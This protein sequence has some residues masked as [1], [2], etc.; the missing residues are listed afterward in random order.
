MRPTTSASNLFRRALCPGSARMEEGLPDEESPQSKEGELLHDYAAH[1]EYDRSF[2]KP[3]QRDLLDLSDAL[4]QLVITRIETLFQSNTQSGR[5]VEQTIEGI[6]SGT[7]DLVIG[8][9]KEAAVLIVDRKFGYKIVERSDLNLQLRGYA[10]ILYDFLEKTPE[11]I[12]V[13]IIQPRLS[14]EKRISLAEYSRTDIEA[15]RK[16]IEQIL[17]RAGH[18]RARLVA[19]EE[20]CRYCK[21]KL[22]CP[23]FRQAFKQLVP[24]RRN[25]IELSKSAREAYLER[26]LSE[27]NDTELE[28]VLVACSFAKMV[29]GQALD[30][31]RKRISAGGFTNYELGKEYSVREIADPQKAISLLTIAGIQTKEQLLQICSLPIGK[32]EEA[33]RKSRKCTWDQARDKINTVLKAVLDLE[34]RKPKVIRK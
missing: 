26:R 16:Q 24:L 7:P 20:Q 12:F 30:E 15:S 19:G 11:K 10:V 33:Y 13:S 1:P 34:E 31:A 29:Q 27:C 23:A 25:S 21:A 9:P 14:Y 3:N 22:T 4:I 5:M 2:L 28:K 18:D 8:Y 6:V 32:I 17:K